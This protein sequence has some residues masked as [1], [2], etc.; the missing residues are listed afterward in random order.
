[1]PRRVYLCRVSDA[2]IPRLMIAIPK[3]S[4]DDDLEDPGTEDMDD[5]DERIP[6]E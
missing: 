1:M 5:K 2:N 3:M 6:S 4:H